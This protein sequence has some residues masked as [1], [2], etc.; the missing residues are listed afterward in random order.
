M[1]PRQQSPAASVRLKAH[2]KW[3]STSCPGADNTHRATCTRM[4]QHTYKDRFSQQEWL[5]N[6]AFSEH[7]ASR[8]TINLPPH[9][10]NCAAGSTHC[11]ATYE[12]SMN[13]QYRQKSTTSPWHKTGANGRLFNPQTTSVTGR[14]R[15]TANEPR[16][17][18]SPSFTAMRLAQ[19]S[20]DNAATG[21]PAKN[22]LSRAYR[23]RDQISV[24]ALGTT[25]DL[26][27]H[28]LVAINRK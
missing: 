24:S 12:R 17:F 13:V 11:L 4:F 18:S 6:I 26:R 27:N 5:I 21:S 7:S 28:G 16:Y 9:A 20:A 14:A 10:C 3:Y 19:T 22:S 15:F 25:A 23:A 8:C 2:L 1:R